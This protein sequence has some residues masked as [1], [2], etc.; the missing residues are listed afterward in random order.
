MLSTMKFVSLMCNFWT[1]FLSVTVI[2]HFFVKIIGIKK[3]K[4]PTE[5]L[6]KKLYVSSIG[7][8]SLIF[9]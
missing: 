9:V 2:Y 6:K 1:I 4:K 3:V 7:F 8:V 5:I